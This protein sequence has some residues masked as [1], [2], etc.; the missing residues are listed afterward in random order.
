MLINFVA[1]PVV[2]FAL[3][4]FIASDRA[5]LLG[6][7]LVLLCPCIDY[8]IV[9]T[10]IAGG[11][12]ERL[13]AA[14]PLLMLLQML[15]LPVY[16]FV[17]V[18]SD[19]TDIIEVNPF[20]EALVIL[21]VVPLAAAGL[22]QALARRSRVGTKLMEVA[23][24][25]MVP[26]MMIV[27]AVVVGSQISEVR[28]E[29]SS[30]AGVAAIYAAFLVVM[31]A[32]GVG[33]ARVLRLDAAARSGAHLHRR[34]PQLPRPPSGP[35]TCPP[36]PWKISRRWATPTSSSSRAA[37][38]PGP[39]R[40]DPGRT[41]SWLT[42]SARPASTVVST[43]ARAPH[44]CATRSSPRSRS[45]LPFRSTCMPRFGKICVNRFRSAH[46]DRSRFENR[47]PQSGYVESGAPRLRTRR[48]SFS[49]A[50]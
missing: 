34:H 50:R 35:E 5:L 32:V 44:P 26:L 31:A 22:T 39:R 11:A 25:V 3:T 42:S 27:L 10:R 41:R 40:D 28:S 7:L 18:G 23:E 8:V 47:P 16:L 29:V 15:L 21:I 24:A 33:L 48:A 43:R 2:V 38:T 45:V 4:R 6:A 14:A 9:F 12:H 19:L 1:V 49:A 30:L 36:T 20:V 17:F 46:T 37:S 13:L